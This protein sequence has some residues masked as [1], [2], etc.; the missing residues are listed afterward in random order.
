[1]N[2]IVFV[3]RTLDSLHSRAYFP[4][5]EISAFGPFCF[6]EH[7]QARQNTR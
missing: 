2:N 5:R 6:Q 1:M 7:N 3:N 4:L